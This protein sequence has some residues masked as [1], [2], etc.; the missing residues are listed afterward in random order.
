MPVEDENDLAVI[1]RCWQ[2]LDG[3]LARDE[4]DTE[5]FIR[6]RNL[7]VVPDAA[8]VLSA[9]AMLLIDDMPGAAAALDLGNA[10][11]RRKERMWRALQAAGVRSL[12]EAVDVDIRQIEE[13]ARDGEVR[14]RISSRL[15]ALVGPITP[16]CR[17]CRSVGQSRWWRP[18]SPRNGRDGSA[19]PGSSG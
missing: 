9:P 10:V 8:S 6:L 12:T 19:V 16:T 14:W 11:I 5:W 13:T 2:M 15:P 4:I 17:L 7:P 18:R 3:A 1:W